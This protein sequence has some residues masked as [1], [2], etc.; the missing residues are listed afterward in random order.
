[1]SISYSGLSN[2]GKAT[3]PSVDGGFGSMNILKDPP[4]SIHTRRIDKVGDHS[5]INQTIG[6]SGN[7]A[8]EYITQYARGVNPMVS[9]SY[10][11]HGNGTGSGTIA[12][13]VQ[14]R[15]G[16]MPYSLGAAGFN[17]RPPVQKPHNLLPLSRQPRP[18]TYSHTA[19]SFPDFSKKLYC[20][21]SANKTHEVKNSMMN[22]SAFPTKTYNL[23]TPI[24]ENFEVKH[25]IKNPLDV[26]A[27]S[28]IKAPYMDITIQENQTPKM[29]IVQDTYAQNSDG[30]SANRSMDI[31]T[32]PIDQVI[33]TQQ[34]RTRE[35]TLNAFATTTKGD[36]TQG[37]DVLNNYSRDMKLPSTLDKGGFFNGASMSSFDNRMGNLPT[38]KSDYKVSVSQKAALQHQ[39]RY[40][41]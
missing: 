20:A 23:D 10:S 16:A 32:T 13:A 41:N 3:L 4:K 7:R 9:V 37:V 29:G 36:G 5:S 26:S 2:Y 34:I 18:W 30:Y 11:N 38:L 14:R 15:N 22:V 33:D 39:S 35:N 28:N 1:M 12:P 25:V 40:Q 31:S 24:K 19:K 27:T 6:D 17:F 21:Q 8:C